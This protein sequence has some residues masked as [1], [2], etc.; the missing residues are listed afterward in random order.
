MRNER[1]AELE[2]LVAEVNAQLDLPGEVDELG[3]DDNEDTEEGWHGVE[4]VPP[5]DHEAEYIDEDKYTTVTVEAMDLSKNGLHKVE[6]ESRKQDEADEVAEAEDKAVA[7]GPSNATKSYKRT[8]TKEKPKDRADKSKKKKF[9]YE[10]KAERKFTRMKQGARN[11]REAK[12]R[13]E[14]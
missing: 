1:K 10:T 3:S 12:A 13:R 4:E 14:K 5:F 8:W 7:M 2:R 6:Q 9:R 11:S